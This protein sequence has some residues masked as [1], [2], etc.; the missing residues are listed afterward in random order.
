MSS[1]TT[2]A[3]FASAP[4]GAG[5]GST[6]APRPSGEALDPRPFAP[7]GEGSAA[8]SL[9]ARTSADHLRVHRRH[10]LK[11]LLQKRDAADGHRAVLARAELP[12]AAA[13]V[14]PLDLRP[15][16]DRFG[17][18]VPAFLLRFARFRAALAAATARRPPRARS[19]LR[20]PRRWGP[21][22]AGADAGGF[23]RFRA[24]W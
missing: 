12:G 10:P 22:R 8:R 23:L 17:L 13:A 4:S 21:L 9:S 20:P 3:A 18:R 16:E 1:S 2:S 15:R 11:R 24:P 5:R 6:A 7:A 14:K 19:P